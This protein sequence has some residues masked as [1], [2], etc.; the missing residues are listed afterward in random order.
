M[1]KILILFSLVTLLNLS[2]TQDKE[3]TF[4]NPMNLNENTKNGYNN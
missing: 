3:K 2:I 4:C 1:K